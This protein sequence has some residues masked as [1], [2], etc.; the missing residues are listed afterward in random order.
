MP[1]KQGEQKTR[2]LW[3]KVLSNDKA[4]PFA[5]VEVLQHRG[6]RFQPAGGSTYAHNYQ[7][8]MLSGILAE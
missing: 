2:S 6:E 4:H 3:I 1:G 7:L 8:G 5:F